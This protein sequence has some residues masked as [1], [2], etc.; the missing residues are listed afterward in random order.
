MP[1]PFKS[2][3]GFSELLKTRPVKKTRRLQL[4]IVK[5]SDDQDSRLGVLVPKRFVK[6]A[7]DRHLIKRIVRHAVAQAAPP[8]H[9]DV[10]VRVIAP[11]KHIP[12]SERQ[13]WWLELDQLLR[14]SSR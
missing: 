6:R 3:T 13:Q 12:D 4:F 14:A 1:A 5:K 11:V 10:L 8:D 9:S 7:V 2:L